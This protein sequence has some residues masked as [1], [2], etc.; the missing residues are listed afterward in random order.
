VVLGG[1][2][3]GK[4]GADGADGADG[5]GAAAALDAFVELAPA[6]QERILEQK[7]C[8][9]SSSK[10]ATQTEVGAHAPARR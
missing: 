4:D 9:N 6:E 5:K 1:G 7:Q 8:V 10:G 2:S 3:S